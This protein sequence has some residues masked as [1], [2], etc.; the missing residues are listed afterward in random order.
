MK[1]AELVDLQSTGVF[2]THRF[3]KVVDG[4][5]KVAQGQIEFG[6]DGYMTL[7]VA[8]EEPTTGFAANYEGYQT[9][10]EILSVS[11]TLPVYCPAP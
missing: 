6:S 9:V 1:H 11:V 5:M 3:K 2:E 7:D 4:D 8:L 10:T